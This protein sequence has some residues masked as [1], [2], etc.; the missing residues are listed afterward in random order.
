LCT[1]KPRDRAQRATSS[2]L[3]STGSHNRTLQL[4][5]PLAIPA[6]VHAITRNGERP[7]E[8]AEHQD[9]SG[10]NEWAAH[11]LSV[12]RLGRRGGGAM[13]WCRAEVRA[14]VIFER[15]PLR[16]TGAVVPTG[17]ATTRT[18]VG[19]GELARIPF[20]SPRD[21]ASRR[22]G[23]LQEPGHDGRGLTMMTELMSDLTISSSTTVRMRMDV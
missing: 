19:P 8:R 20:D 11:T 13:R 4:W 9:A 21:R 23:D 12:V 10:A 14:G 1:S 2:C 7:Y 3:V 6:V 17:T 22:Q 18:S 15:L 16:V 5:T